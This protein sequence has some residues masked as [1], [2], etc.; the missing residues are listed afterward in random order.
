[1]RIAVV[2]TS[3]SGKTTLAK[4][5]A[6]QLALPYIELDALNW[7]PGWRDLSRNDPDEFV[8][9]VTLTVAADTWV[10]D[11]NYG[12]VRE[13]VWRRATHLVWLDYDRAVIMYRVIR[14]S[15]VRAMLRTELWAG[16]RERWLHMLRPSHPIR[17][18]WS[19]WARRRKEYEER[20]GLSDYAH[21][22]VLRLRRPR[23]AKK[24]LRRLMRGPDAPGLSGLTGFRPAS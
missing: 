8:R 1:L 3:G 12:L 24:L 4:A 22:V 5:L 7:Q 14:R 18:A 21:L 13:F 19:T 11:G 9:R 10:V 6:A 16:N 17:W 20:I 2:G 23:D 15:L